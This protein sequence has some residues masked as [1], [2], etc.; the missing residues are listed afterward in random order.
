MTIRWDQKVEFLVMPF[1]FHT[2]AWNSE[3]ETKRIEKDTKPE[4]TEGEDHVHQHKKF[5]A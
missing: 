2:C 3:V 4:L 5:N 1:F